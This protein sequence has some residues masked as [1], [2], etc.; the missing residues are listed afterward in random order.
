MVYSK[1]GNEE[2]VQT[3]NLNWG[4]FSPIIISKEVKGKMVKK[5]GKILPGYKRK[6]VQVIRRKTKKGVTVSFKPLNYIRK[7]KK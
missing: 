1:L 5:K 3:L 6:R 7:K 4:R 2:K